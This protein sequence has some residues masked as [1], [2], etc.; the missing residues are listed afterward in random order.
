MK[1]PGWVWWALA[2]GSA[3]LMAWG[4][5]LSQFESE[6]SAV[7][8]VGLVLTFWSV[9]STIAA[10][11]GIASLFQLLFF[12]QFE[13]RLRAGAAGAAILMTSTVVGAVAGIP[14]LVAIYSSRKSVRP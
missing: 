12:R 2:A 1:T 4:W 13:R 9:W 8:R 14:V 10:L 3:V 6:P 7:G 5:F 11:G